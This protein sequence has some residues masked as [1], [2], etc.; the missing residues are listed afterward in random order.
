MFIYKTN[1]VERLVTICKSRDYV[2]ANED[3]CP[4]LENPYL[5]DDTELAIKYNEYQSGK[6]GA[7]EDFV[8]YFYMHGPEL[9][10]G[11]LMDWRNIVLNDQEL[12]QI[13]INIDVGSLTEAKVQGEAG[14]FSWFGNLFE[15]LSNPCQYAKPLSGSIGTLTETARAYNPSSG[16]EGSTELYLCDLPSEMWNKIPKDF[17]SMITSLK[18]GIGDMLDQLGNATNLSDWKGI[19]PDP[20]RI[21]H[22]ELF[23]GDLFATIGAQ[24]GDCFRILEYNKRYNPYNG[25]QNKTKADRLGVVHYD[26]DGN[27]IGTTIGGHWTSPTDRAA[28]YSDNSRLNPNMSVPAI[29]DN[30]IPSVSNGKTIEIHLTHYGALL[31][32]SGKF[33]TDPNTC[34]NDDLGNTCTTGVNII[35]GYIENC[36]TSIN[37]G[38]PVWNCCMATNDKN[39]IGYFS[40]IAVTQLDNRFQVTGKGGSC[41]LLGD[42][43]AKNALKCRIYLDGGINFE[44]PI[45]DRT[46]TEK[47][48]G[49]PVV[50]VTLMYYLTKAGRKCATLTYTSGDNRGQT[51]GPEEGDYS[52]L[53]IKPSEF[54][55]IDIRRIGSTGKD[56]SVNLKGGSEVVRGLFYLDDSFCKENNLPVEIYGL[57][58]VL[59]S[60]KPVNNSPGSQT[61][62]SKALTLGTPENLVKSDMLDQNAKDSSGT[63]IST[64]SG[65]IWTDTS[66]TSLTTREENFI[67]NYNAMLTGL[68]TEPYSDLYSQYDYDTFKY[69]DITTKFDNGVTAVTLNNTVY[70]SSFGQYFDTS[71]NN[72]TFS[73]DYNIFNLNDINNTV[74]L[75]GFNMNTMSF[76]VFKTNDIKLSGVENLNLY[77][78]A[79]EI[80][81]MLNMVNLSKMSMVDSTTVPYTGGINI[82][83]SSGTV[84]SINDLD[85][86]RGINIIKIN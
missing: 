19:R 62:T 10:I 78:A 85:N 75:E 31:L 7:A 20:Y 42:A 13:A 12:S 74:E 35:P 69:G 40:A 39:I 60:S 86:T 14:S 80:I 70:E 45:Y 23:C 43:R 66:L 29:T 51:I 26:K 82:T 59:S 22:S 37:D 2:L 8:T 36:K 24:L 55:N 79:G 47:I 9:D 1:M 6:P 17:T 27:A 65:S 53:Q 32:K 34:T 38:S 72:I 64:I 18:T 48:K 81:P 57:S 56:I 50:D 84:F 15:C 58:G 52:S 46:G 28:T 76:D 83:P 33:Y 30:V 67:N 49:I 25:T 73:S 44:L 4:L 41:K 11:S 77:D 71:G 21:K 16:M 63:D 68:N 5:K 54:K 3:L 61:A